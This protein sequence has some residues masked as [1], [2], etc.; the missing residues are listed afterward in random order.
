MAI[1][2]RPA[3]PKSALA[4]L[5][6]MFSPDRPHRWTLLVLSVTVTSLLLWAF[7]LDTRTPPKERQIIY[8]ESW[9]AD[10]KDSD[11]I[12]RQL[13]DLTEYEGSLRTEQVSFQKVADR[14]GIEW[15]EEE[16]RNRKRREETIAAVKKNLEKKLATALEREGKL[17]T[18]Q[19][20][21]APGASSP[22]TAR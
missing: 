3:S 21:A 8:V 4:D 17:A 9:M 13:K 10:R 12:K 11:I 2:P 15:R 22:P 7:L 1:F 6:D 19:A 20:G 5:R 16:A 18:A 14:L